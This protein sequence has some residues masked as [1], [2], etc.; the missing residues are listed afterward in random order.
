MYSLIEWWESQ[1]VWQVDPAK[2]QHHLVDIVTIE[3]WMK[4]IRHSQHR[5]V[6]TSFYHRPRLL[7]HGLLFVP[8]R[9]LHGSMQQCCG[10]SILASTTRLMWRLGYNHGALQDVTWLCV[11]TFQPASSSDHTVFLRSLKVASVKT[12]LSS[13]HRHTPHDSMLSRIQLA[14][15]WRVHR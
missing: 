7:R 3:T 11:M 15:T 5:A 8:R 14:I 10:D 4:M 13:Y 12:H 9:W 1:L 2:T 6:V